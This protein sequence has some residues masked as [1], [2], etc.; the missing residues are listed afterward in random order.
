[1]KQ[2]GVP[3]HQ[4]I[5]LTDV[6]DA[7]P[8]NPKGFHFACKKLEFFKTSIAQNQSFAREHWLFERFEGIK[9]PSCA[10]REVGNQGSLHI[11]FRLDQ[12]PSVIHLDSISIVRARDRI[13]GQAI[14]VDDVGLMIEHRRVDQQH[15]K[16]LMYCK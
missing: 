4:F 8:S 3:M 16:C 10:F 11:I 13:T 15:Q 5:G 12:Q 7:W 9:P 14:Y 1:M 6:L 2:L